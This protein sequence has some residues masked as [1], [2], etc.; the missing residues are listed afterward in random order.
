MTKTAVTRLFVG[1]IIAVLA[2]LFLTI[3]A[4]L[5]AVFSGAFVVNGPDVVE[6][7]ATPQAWTFV[8][9]GVIGVLA[10][11][12][13]SI[14]GLVAWI[15]ALLNTAQLPDKAWFLVLLLLGL[16]SF[17]FIA[18]LAYVIAG[19]DGTRQETPQ[20]P[21]TPQTTQAWS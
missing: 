1:G 3:A 5:I 12:G 6:I 13:G 11:I 9:L 16:F 19:P 2:G 20:T 7:N 17:G 14:A 4:F 8:V 15:G 10:L 18:M 21:P